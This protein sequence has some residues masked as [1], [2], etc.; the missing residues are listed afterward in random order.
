MFI[1]DHKKNIQAFTIERENVTHH[2]RQE[3]DVFGRRTKICKGVNRGADVAGWKGARLP[4]VQKKFFKTILMAVV[5]NYW[6]RRN[7][8]PVLN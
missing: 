6:N 4:F 5:C 3:S 7:I 1:L 8:L 2:I